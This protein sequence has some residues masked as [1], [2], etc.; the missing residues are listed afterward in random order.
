[1]ASEVIEYFLKNYFHPEF[2]G[3]AVS[4][5]FGVTSFSPQNFAGVISSVPRN[6]NSQYLMLLK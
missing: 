3:P 1:M 5:M 4:A 2:H 6:K